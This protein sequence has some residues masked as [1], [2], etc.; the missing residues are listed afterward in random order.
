MCLGGGGSDRHELVGEREAAAAAA[1]LLLRPVFHL[2]LG[3]GELHGL[4]RGTVG[5][6]GMR[7]AGDACVLEREDEVV[8]LV[9]P[10]R[11]IVSRASLTGSLV[12]NADIRAVVAWS[13]VFCTVNAVYERRPV[14]CVLPMADAA[15]R[16]QF[17]EITRMS[18]SWPPSVDS[19]LILPVRRVCTCRNTS[20]ELCDAPARAVTSGMTIAMDPPRI[21]ATRPHCV[22]DGP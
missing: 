15:E 22:V 7:H 11:R 21:G 4:D 2:H 13:I 10:A 9:A 18:S 6:R 3:E 16:P 20:L 5:A 19:P 12:A 1:G 14:A 8:R 17:Q